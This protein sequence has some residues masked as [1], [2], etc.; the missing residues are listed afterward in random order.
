[1]VGCTFD[2]L[3]KVFF[4]KHPSLHVHQIIST[5]EEQLRHDEG[6]EDVAGVELEEEDGDGAWCEFVNVQIDME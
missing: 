4:L 5:Q 1:M 6:E 2:N 3:E